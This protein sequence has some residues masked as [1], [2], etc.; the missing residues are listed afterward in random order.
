[1]EKKWWHD[2]VAYQI[3]PKSFCDT[4]GDGIGDLRGIIEKLDYLKELGADIIWISPVYCSP[5]KDQGYDISDYYNIDPVFGTIEDMEE[6]LSEARKRELYILMDLV[7]NHCSS[8]HEWFQKALQDPEGEYGRYFYI[9]RGKD[10]MP[11]NNWRGNFGGSAWSRI[12]GTDLYYLHTFHET[13]PDLNWENPAVRRKLYEM[14]N[15]W[16]EKGLAGFRIDAI[17]NIKKELHFRN[18]P[19]DR[20]DGTCSIRC[21]LQEAQG[22]GE[23]LTELRENTFDRYNAFTVAEV[24]DNKPEELE[25]FIGEDGY[26]STMFDFS[27]ESART[28]DNWYEMNQLRPEEIKKIIFDSQ[29]RTREIGL[30]ANIIENHD[31][32]RGASAFFAEEPDREE[33]KTMLAVLQLLQRGIPFLYQG[34]ELGMT[35]VV[36]Q[37]IA[38]V[39]DVA[40]RDQYQAAL[41]AGYSEEEAL[42]IVN[43]RSRDN[44]RT[45]FQWSSE[46]NAG[47]TDGTPWLMVN[48]NYRKINLKSQQRD[49][50]SVYS[51]YKK[52]IRLRK[53]EEYKDTFVYGTFRPAYE[54]HNNIFAYYRESERQRIAVIANYQKESQE[55]MLTDQCE[56]V[57]LN[58]YRDLSLK[59][60]RLYLEG[61]QAV[62]LLLK[63]ISC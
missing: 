17:I 28:G 43:L 35:N 50:R 15:W 29:E 31:E 5:M 22:I 34:Q 6:L 39:D 59:D 18:Y 3:Y 62:V 12:E 33:S 2:K 37:D 10:G 47:F 30:L 27:I 49:E 57:L 24:F 51:F 38:Q 25:K 7:I 58:N 41:E 14:I 48:S 63:K 60:G 16:L 4:N 20:E 36:F 32:P 23:F 46:K 53:E 13:Q 56:K 52:L 1:M 45:P 40:S 9:R 21:M 55:L 8:E 19:A 42:R 11:P 54:E 26:F 61:Y 44:C